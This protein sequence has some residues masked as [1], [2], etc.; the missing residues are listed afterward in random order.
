MYAV[1]SGSFNPPTIAHISIAKEL[2]KEPDIEKVI[3]VPVGNQYKKNDL[4]HLNHR[5]AMLQLYISKE[6]RF[7]VSDIFAKLDNPLDKI[8]LLDELIKIYPKEKL[9]FAMG[10]DNLKDIINWDNWQNLVENYKFIIIP[11]GLD[12]GSKFIDNNEILKKYKSN[13]RIAHYQK[14]DISS[15]FVRRHIKNGIISKDISPDVYKY[16]IKNK[17]Y[18]QK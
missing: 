16:I 14:I 4:I 3:L 6:P 8:N 18:E 12:D 7:E 11:R 17:L 5:I 13:F 9:C 15:T 2:L 10:T 1:F